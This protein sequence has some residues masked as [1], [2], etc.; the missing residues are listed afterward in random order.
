MIV[1]ICPQRSIEKRKKKTI[2]LI[3]SNFKLLSLPPGSRFL[4]QPQL[5]PAYKLCLTTSAKDKIS[6]PQ[7][8]ALSNNCPI[9]TC[10]YSSHFL[11]SFPFHLVYSS[12]LKGN[13]SLPAMRY[14]RRHSIFPIIIFPLLLLYN[15]LPLTA[16][17]NSD[18]VFLFWSP[19]LF[20]FDDTN[21]DIF[22]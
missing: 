8:K 18:K 9:I 16:V 17:F 15:Y 5:E 4:T 14:S 20:L 6:W 13:S 7:R 19:D 21:V 3:C 1:N 12:L 10:I 2:Y 11:R 22:F